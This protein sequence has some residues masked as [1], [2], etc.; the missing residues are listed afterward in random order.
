MLGFTGHYEECQANYDVCRAKWPLYPEFI[1]PPIHFAAFQGDW[2]RFDRLSGIAN[3]LGQADAVQEALR[4][5]KMLREPT[6][7]RV[8]SLLN[9]IEAQLQKNGT[10]EFGPLV[11]AYK[12]GLQDETFA[13]VDR[14]SF[15]NLFADTGPPPAGQFLPGVIFDPISKSFND[16]GPALR[17]LLREDRPLPILD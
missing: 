14:A 16:A 4:V 7:W 6:P 1:S 15:A 5:G 2:P 11:V 3:T 17:G 8:Q 10:V 13:F 12:L 9:F